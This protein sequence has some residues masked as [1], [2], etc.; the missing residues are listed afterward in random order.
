[1]TDLFG[2]VQLADLTCHHNLLHPPG[3]RDGK[4]LP[5]TAAFSPLWFPDPRMESEEVGVE[6]RIVSKSGSSAL[7]AE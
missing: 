5:I 7:A 1:M 6:A 2:L 3:P 4:F